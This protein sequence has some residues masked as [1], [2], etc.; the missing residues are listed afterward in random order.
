MT[1]YSIDRDINTNNSE[2][3][4][5]EVTIFSSSMKLVVKIHFEPFI[6]VQ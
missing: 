3:I 1:N 4:N 6:Y 5:F 2:H